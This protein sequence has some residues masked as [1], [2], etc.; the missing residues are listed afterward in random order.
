MTTKQA[1]DDFFAQPALAV[2]GVSRSGKKFGNHAYRELKSRGYKV[3]PVHPA[4]DEIEGDRCYAGLDKLPER[5]EGLV[6]VVPP[7]Q[8]EKVVRKAA[9]TGIR[10]IWMQQGAE[11]EEA[12]R[13]CEERGINV[14]HGECIM[15]FMEGASFP[16]RVHRWV[17]KLLGKLPS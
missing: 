7:A 13:F 15:M 1:I 14:V 16:H 4:A 11:S 17:W 9:E 12:I 2:I 6:L 5:V 10:R 3:F 8:T